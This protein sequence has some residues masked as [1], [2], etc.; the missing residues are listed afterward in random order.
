[1]IPPRHRAIGYVRVSTE[2]QVDQGSSLE[3][4]TQRVKQYAELYNL[5]LVEIIV[6]PGHSAKTLARPGLQRALGMLNAG[7]ADALLVTKL[8]RLTRSVRDLGSL[9]DDYFT[10]KFALLSVGEQ[11][12]TS[13][14]GGRLVLNILG[15]ISSWERERIGERTREAVAYLR[16]QGRV[17]SKHPPYGWRA[18]GKHVVPNP[19][20]QRMIA[21][22]RDLRKMGYSYTWI[23]QQYR[24]RIG[25][26]M[27]PQQ[28]K[29]LTTSVAGVR[30]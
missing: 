28:V 26:Q 5:E 4:Q 23:A 10:N 14:P 15:S 2:K 22:M 6:D 8:D 30:L 18:E 7:Q 21:E 20:E 25:T 17:V 1:M 3:A 19:E 29:R 13:T 11:I 24:T 12:D 27:A 16:T 9:I